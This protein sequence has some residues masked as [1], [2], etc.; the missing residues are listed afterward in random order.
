MSHLTKQELSS[1]LDALDRS[2]TR[3]GVT[4]SD[5]AAMRRAKAKLETRAEAKSAY[6]AGQRAYDASIKRGAQEHEALD[7][8]D[9]AEETYWRRAKH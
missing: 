4:K 2:I 7:A 5:A 9:N 1:T 6:E 8:W 3:R